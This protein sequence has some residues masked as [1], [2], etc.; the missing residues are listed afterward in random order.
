MPLK[1]WAF[2]KMIYIVPQG[3]CIDHTQFRYV[4]TN[5]FD[6]K[7]IREYGDEWIFFTSCKAKVKI[8]LFKVNVTAHIFAPFHATSQKSNYIIILG[9]VSW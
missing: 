2:Y 5:K 3:K 4:R 1:I 9:F 8:K 6:A 7:K